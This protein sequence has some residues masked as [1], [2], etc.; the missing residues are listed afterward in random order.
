MRML[1]GRLLL[2]VLLCGAGR[3]F[4]QGGPPALPA[5]DAKASA[6]LGR[7]WRRA[8]ARDPN[9]GARDL[10]EFFLTAVSHGWRP[11]HWPEIINLAEELHDRDPASPTYGNYRWYRREARVNDR[12]AVEFSMQSA[13]LAWVLYRNRLPAEARTQLA[14]A[15]ALGAEGMLRHK[16]DVSYTNIFLMRLANCILIGEATQ[17]PDLVAQGRRWLDEWNDY[18]RKNGIH[19]FNSPTYYGTDLDDLGALGNYAQAPEVRAAAEQALLL[20]WND[21]ASNWF[22]P[23][24]GIAGAHS[25]DYGFLTGHGYLD[26]ALARAGWI[27]AH[28]IG[29]SHPAI[30]DLT[31]WRPPPQLREQAENGSPRFFVHSWGPHPWERTAH[32]VGKDFS[33]G[34]SGAGYGAQDKVLALTL[35]GGPRMPIV[36]FSLDYRDD[37]Y[38]QKKMGT[39][40]GHAKLTHLLPFIASVQQ[41]PEALLVAF[42]NP[43]RAKNPAGGNQPIEYAGMNANFVLPAAAALWDRHGPLAAGATVHVERRSPLFLHYGRT[44]AALLFVAARDDAGKDVRAAVVRDGQAVAAA[45]LTAVLAAGRPRRPVWVAVW[46]RAAENIET[47]DEFAA[48]RTKFLE[49]ARGAAVS[50]GHEIDVTVPGESAPLHL[51]IDPKRE[52]RS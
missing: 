2:V 8:A 1:I 50:A 47:D 7:T 4:A 45:R 3:G 49:S 35:S 20:F 21:I 32:Y 25:R 28:V 34:S 9:I 38:G 41:G 27:D 23:Y 5:L 17:R 19:E 11:E 36:N 52:R 13:S 15:L 16:V 22:A 48:F 12:N 51:R 6:I 37:P 46:V 30:D 39:A 40:D 14:S 42:Y 24:Q 26:Q 10:Y 33:L 18:T 44:A 43:A 29:E 31:F